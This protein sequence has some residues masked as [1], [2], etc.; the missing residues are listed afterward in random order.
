MTKATQVIAWVAVSILIIAGALF[1][2]QRIANATPEVKVNWCHATSSNSN[3]YEAIQVSGNAGGHTEH[4]KDF[5]Y[6][7]PLDS[8]NK[9]T[10]DGDDWCKRN[11]PKPPVD[12]CPNLDG[13]QTEVPKGYAL[14]DGKCIEVEVVPNETDLCPNIEGVQATVPDG[15]ELKDGKCVEVIPVVDVCNNIDGV[16]ATIPAGYTWA[17]NVCTKIE[18]PTTPEPLP[19]NPDTGQPYQGK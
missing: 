16:Q 6:A 3:P 11:A 15:F 4:A 1:I 9:P 19:V 10:K 18:V 8:K 12:V 17:K 13:T 7:G 14:K 5:K 2:G